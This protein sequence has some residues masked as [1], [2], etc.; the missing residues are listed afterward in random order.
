MFSVA[1][2]RSAH[3]DW[4]RLWGGIRIST[5]LQLQRKCLIHEQVDIPQVLSQIETHH[6]HMFS[7]YV[8]PKCE[9]GSFMINKNNKTKITFVLL[10][11][12]KCLTP[13]IKKTR[14]RFSA[15]L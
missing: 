5:W 15:V 12:K 4:R 14:I 11:L 13:K 9:M 10:S 6:L 7:I 3:S 8:L 2:E 1:R